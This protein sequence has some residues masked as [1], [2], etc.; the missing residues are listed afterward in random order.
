VRPGTSGV[1]G[2]AGAGGTDPLVG[3][4]GKDTLN[5]GGGNDRLEGD[6]GKDTLTGGTGKDKFE[7][8]T[9]LNASTNVDRIT[10]FQPV[11]DTIQLDRTIFTK[12]AT[13]NLA[14]GAFHEGSAA[15]D[16]SDRIVY[17]EDTGSLY[18]DADGNS[19]G[20]SAILFATLV[21]TPTLTAADFFIVA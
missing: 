7:F 19:S 16:S 9:A 6:A 8:D 5:G 21:G 11:D 1:T 14:A 3:A 12:L 15:H 18:Y 10:D 13:G 2:L 17:N 4:G 20:S